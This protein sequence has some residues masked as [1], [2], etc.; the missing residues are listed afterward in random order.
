MSAV[1]QLREE[2][3]GVAKK[4][5]VME[6]AIKTMNGYIRVLKRELD[7]RTPAQQ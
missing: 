2:L 4:K 1:Q 5:L 3:Y 7:Q 6:E